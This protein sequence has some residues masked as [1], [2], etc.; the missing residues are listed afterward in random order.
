MITK[1]TIISPFSVRQR[2]RKE[3]GRCKVST[4]GW[5]WLT[6]YGAVSATWCCFGTRALILLTQKNY[7]ENSVSNFIMW[8]FGILH[9]LFHAFPSISLKTVYL[10]FFVLI[11]SSPCTS[12]VLVMKL[13]GME[14]LDGLEQKG[15]LC[16]CRYTCVWMS[17]SRNRGASTGLSEKAVYFLDGKW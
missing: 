15:G 17:R 1:I 5:G 14:A 11:L 16:V 13:W 6:E 3:D 7:P 4:T 9:N 12:V 10:Y 8:L 2:T